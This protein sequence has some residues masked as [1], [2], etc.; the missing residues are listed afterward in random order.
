MALIFIVINNNKLNSIL[1]LPAYAASFN[2]NFIQRDEGLLGN[3][4]LGL[5]GYLYYTTTHT[6]NSQLSQH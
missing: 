6:V 4:I 3:F 5:A 2:G 1:L